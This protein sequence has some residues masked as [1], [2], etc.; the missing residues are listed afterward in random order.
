MCWWIECARLKVN[1]EFSRLCPPIAREQSA[2]E[3]VASGTLPAHKTAI[4]RKISAIFK[5]MLLINANQWPCRALAARRFVLACD[6]AAVKEWKA[7][8]S[9]NRHGKPGST[10]RADSIATILKRAGARAGIDATNLVGH[11]MRAGMESARYS[12]FQLETEARFPMASWPISDDPDSKVRLAPLAS[13]L[14]ELLRE[15]I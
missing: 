2:D 11:S 10:L 14:I 5:H 6:R 3:P 7:F 1:R 13:S 15:W 12:R 8:R 9:I 4:R